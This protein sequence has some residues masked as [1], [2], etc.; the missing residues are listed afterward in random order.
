MKYVLIV[1]GI[2]FIGNA[3]NG[4]MWKD[5]IKMMEENRDE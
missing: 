5:T 1:L 4:S 2:L 3:I